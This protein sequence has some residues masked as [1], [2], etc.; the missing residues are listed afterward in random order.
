MFILPV[1]VALIAAV[2]LWLWDAAK[3]GILN[4]SARRRAQEKA[5]QEEEDIKYDII[6]KLTNG[7]RHAKM[8]LWAYA[9]WEGPD[10]TA[11][12]R[13]LICAFPVC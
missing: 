7:P 1:L 3:G 4:K 2:L 11:H 12:L 9:D 8:C 13:S 6:K 5:E 10:Q